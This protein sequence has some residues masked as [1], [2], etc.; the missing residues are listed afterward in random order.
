[1]DRDEPGCISRCG[2]GDRHASGG[3]ALL[4]YTPAFERYQ[5]YETLGYG[6]AIGLGAVGLSL[7][8][9]D[10]LRPNIDEVDR[11]PI[12]GRPMDTPDPALLNQ[13]EQR[14]SVTP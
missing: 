1:M 3:P 6:T 2:R 14:N 11:N 13:S 4:R 5:S 12:Y 7:I 9:W 10:Y 8:I